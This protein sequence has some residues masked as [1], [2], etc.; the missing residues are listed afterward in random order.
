M[1]YLHEREVVAQLWGCAQTAKN[2]TYDNLARTLRF[3]YTKGIISK[4][5]EK[6]TYRFDEKHLTAFLEDTKL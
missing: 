5:E 4:C 6:F 2:M 1:F 3:Y